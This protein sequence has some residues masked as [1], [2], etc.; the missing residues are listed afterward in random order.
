MDKTV[1]RKPMNT[2]ITHQQNCNK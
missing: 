1:S 2:D